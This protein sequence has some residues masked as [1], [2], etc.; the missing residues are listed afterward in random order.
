[1]SFL[2]LP[3][4][5]IQRLTVQPNE[6]KLNRQSYNLGEVQNMAVSCRVSEHPAWKIVGA[7]GRTGP[8]KQVQAS[9]YS[10]TR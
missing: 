2:A 1:M 10:S 6:E 9:N 5:V 8:V 3:N 7:P 4:G